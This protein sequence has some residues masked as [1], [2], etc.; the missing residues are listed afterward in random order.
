MGGRTRISLSPISS[1]NC[2]RV[3]ILRHSE[4]MGCRLMAPSMGF[5]IDPLFAAVSQGWDGVWTRVSSLLFSYWSLMIEKKRSRRAFR[6]ADFP[7]YVL[8]ATSMLPGLLDISRKGFLRKAFFNPGDPGAEGPGGLST[9]VCVHTGGAPE[10]EGSL[11]LEVG[12][13]CTPALSPRPP[14]THTPEAAWRLWCWVRDGKEEAPATSKG[15]VGR[16]GGN[17]L[18]RL[19][20]TGFLLPSC[21]KVLLLFCSLIKSCIYLLQLPARS[22][23]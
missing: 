23:D 1:V 13:H 2:M 18:P 12:P 3:F 7:S 8:P 11:I 6:G 10:Q 15:E 17:Q 14:N 19:R 16:R 22:L 9:S 4:K 21:M 5:H 20:E